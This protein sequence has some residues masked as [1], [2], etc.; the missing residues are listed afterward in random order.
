[1][2]ITEAAKL[3]NSMRLGTGPLLSFARMD[4][5]TLEREEL[6]SDEWE[7][8]YQKFEMEYGSFPWAMHMLLAG[9]EVKCKGGEWLK[10]HDTQWRAHI[11]SF[12]A[13]QMHALWEC[14]EP[15]NDKEKTK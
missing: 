14:R 10:P 9:M 13:E 1:M 15:A 4:S 6:V 2:T 12:Y 7:P 8:V 5:F 3:S 11:F